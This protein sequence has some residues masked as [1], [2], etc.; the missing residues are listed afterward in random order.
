QSGAESVL[1]LGCGE[2]KLLRL[3]LKERQFRRI[4][5]TDVSYGELT[6]AMDRLHYEDLPPKQWERLKLWQGALTYRDERMNGFDAAAVVEVI[7]HLD[8]NRL[9]AFERVVFGSARPSTV[10]VTTPNAEYNTLFEQMEAGTMRHTDHRFEWSRDEFKAWT[11]KTAA[12]FQYQ[13]RIEPIG[14]VD[15]RYGAPSQ[16]A[17]FTYGD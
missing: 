15:E 13:V 17:I 5:G 7:E 4:E 1:D 9:Q 16:M 12:E 2:G 6:K 11:E 10:V 8:E 3:L 14:P